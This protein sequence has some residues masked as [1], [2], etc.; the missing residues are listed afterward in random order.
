MFRIPDRTLRDLRWPELLRALAARAST[1]FG[2]ELALALPFLES[3]GEVELSLA[4][5]AEA[6]RLSEL[7]LQLPLHALDDAREA[8]RKADKRAVLEPLELMGV[9]RLARGVARVKVHLRDR[10]EAPL[11]GEL[12]AELPDVGPL[13][14]RIDG[15]FEESGRLRDTASSQ[16]ASLRDRARGLHGTIKRRLEEKLRDEQFSMYL[17]ES[18]V[19]IRNDRYVVPVNSSFQQNVPGIV[20]N[21]SNTGQTLFVEPDFLVGLGNDLAVAESMIAEEERRILTELSEAVG[22]RSEELT[23]AVARLALLDRIEACGKLASELRAHEPTL[24]AAREG[25]QLR[26]ARHPLLVLSGRT[27]VANELRIA[28]E[29]RVLVVSGPNA[30]GKTVTLSTVGLSALLLRAGLPIPAAEGSTLPLFSN[31]HTA[32]GDA[33][34]LDKGLST[35]SAHLHELK[36]ILESAGP[37]SLVL[38]DEIAADTDP[39]EGA[40]LASAVLHEL[41]ERGARVLVSTH[42]EELKALG[43]GDPRYANARVGLDPETLAPTFQ[44]ELGQVGASSALELAA[45]AG[46]PANV[47]ERARER[48]HGGSALAQALTRLDAERRGFEQERARFE[49][50]RKELQALAGAAERI[51]SQLAQE[52]KEAEARV[53]AELA[54]RLEQAERD[55]AAI[56]AK[57]TQAPKVGEA[58][59]AQAE[60]RRQA[61]Q[62][63]KES[64]QAS[65][66]QHAAKEAIVQGVKLPAKPSPG[67]RVRIA[68]LGKDGVVVEVTATD[69][70]VQVGI[71]KTRVALEEL[72]PL[73][74]KGPT[75][76]S[77]PPGKKDRLG[78][79]AAAAAGV[80]ASDERRC[81]VRGLRAEEAVKEVE[82]FLDRAY[83]EGAGSVVVLHGHGTG[84]LKKWLREMLVA[85]PY[86]GKHRPGGSHEGGDAVTVIELK[87]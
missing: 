25:M 18:Y 50:E 83:A 24:G 20:H 57:L 2:A 85:S 35:F 22:A 3:A 9:A 61:E 74:G 1:V 79:A 87:G 11:L 60:L 16:L 8:L 32:I 26:Q 75:G 59:A 67:A 76:P 7:Q 34:D 43:L 13:A 19:S 81:D 46:L 55:A 62:A 71:L 65:A 78:N 37:G 10:A 69:A 30:G 17:R 77:T 41:V 64:N 42:L 45:R 54:D 51:A 58:V 23:A 66:R 14:S 27:V 31:V 21:A 36:R 68:S 52:K 63:R 49:R 38:V 86:V 84:A 70:V 40:A 33:Q 4:R 56:V 12:A 80:I 82:L 39:R 5:I 28:A 29:E 6:R 72:Q 44:L 48:L 73:A 15:C 47:V 53:R